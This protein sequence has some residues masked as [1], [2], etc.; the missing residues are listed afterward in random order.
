MR[1]EVALARL[2]DALRE[3]AKRG[4]KLLIRLDGFR[5]AGIMTAK[6]AD[7]DPARGKLRTWVLGVGLDG[8]PFKEPADRLNKATESYD[9][10]LTENEYVAVTGRKSPE[11]EG[12]D[13][14]IE[15]GTILEAD[16]Q[17]RLLRELQ[18]KERTV[19]SLQRKL[20]EAVK[21]QQ[22]WMVQAEAEAAQ[23]RE[24]QSRQAALMRELYL[25]RARE[26]SLR[27]SLLMYINI[28]AEVESA[29]RR[30]I[31]FASQRGAELAKTEMERAEDALRRLRSL[32][33]EAEGLTGRPDVLAELKKL[34]EMVKKAPAA[35]AAHAG[36]AAAG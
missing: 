25:L 30:L 5:L 10:V 26:A 32:R 2:L 14:F 22:F 24:L 13:N 29:I 31:E 36:A 35:G 4:F 15:F 6:R 18:E 12:D 27:E 17:R 28:S 11:G 33:E 16:A 1:D 9:M 8:R 34:E 21:A 3:G 19:A 23:S 7:L 20:D